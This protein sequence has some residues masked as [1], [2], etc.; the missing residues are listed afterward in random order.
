MAEEIVVKLCVVRTVSRRSTSSA[1]S[2]SDRSAIREALSELSP[3]YLLMLM[4][5]LDL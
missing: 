2:N 5:M 4:L 3:R 1:C